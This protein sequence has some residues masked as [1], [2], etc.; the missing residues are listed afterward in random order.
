[1]RDRFDADDGDRIT[2]AVELI[3]RTGARSFEVFYIDD[4]DLEASE[5]LWT[6]QVVHRGSKVWETT[7]DP[8][9]S[10]EQLAAKIVT[11][12]MCVH[13][14]RQTAITDERCPPFG[15]ICGYY[16]QG[17]RYLRSCQ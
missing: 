17:N 4:P 14:H 1:M 12:G 16:R 2:A 11:G 5:T 7:T 10:T 13:C 3:A 8:I 9:D 15:L 6:A